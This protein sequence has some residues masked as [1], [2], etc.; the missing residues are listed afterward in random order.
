MPRGLWD[1]AERERS[2]GGEREDWMSGIQGIVAENDDPEGMH[3]VK[4]YVTV[5]SETEVYDVWCKQM[6]GMVGPPGYGSYSVPEVGAEVALFGVL[7]EKYTLY[8]V[9]VYNETYQTPSDFD[10]PAVAGFRWHGS[11]KSLVE[12]DH[13]MRAGRLNVEVKST[14][15]LIAPGGIFFN[16]RPVS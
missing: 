4:C 6:V 9:P 14:I 5:V 3:R 11:F 7:N 1:V 2:S 15:N 13:M 16:G 12:L 10:S 8:Y